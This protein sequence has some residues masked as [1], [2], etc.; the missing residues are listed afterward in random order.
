MFSKAMYALV[1]VVARDRGLDGV[2]VIGVCA[3]EKGMQFASTVPA[4]PQERRRMLLPF[5]LGAR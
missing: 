3:S 1:M 4:L 2:P 5:Y